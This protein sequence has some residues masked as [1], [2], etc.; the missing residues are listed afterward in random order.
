MVGL[1]L[2]VLSIPSGPT[3]PA[4]LTSNDLQNILHPLRHTA[5]RV[6]TQIETFANNLESFKAKSPRPHDTQSFLEACD[7]MKKYRETAVHSMKELSKN[8]NA[9]KSKHTSPA[10]NR[11]NGAQSSSSKLDEQIRRWQLEAETWDLF[12]QILCVNDPESRIRAKRAAKTSLQILHRYSTD[13][14]VWEKFLEVDHFA[15]ECVVVL[16]WLE[17]TS[18]DFTEDI[19]AL[20]S[21]LE[22]KAERGQG[23]WA[24]GWLY[25]KEAIKGAKRLR[26]WP[27]PLDP[28]DPGITISL[29][30]S[31]QKESLIT[32]LDPDAVTRQRHGLQKQDRFYEQA[33]WLTCWKMLRQGES[34]SKIRNWSEEHLENWR[35]ISLCGAVGSSDGS[36]DDGNSRMMSYKSQESWR[37][38]CSALANN[39]SS[40]PFERAVYALLCGE[41]EPAYA[42]CRGWS[43]HLYVYLNHVILSRYR[44]F[45]KQLSRK[46]SY[47]PSND[48][49]LVLE[50]PAYANLNG[51]LNSMHNNERIK[52]EARNPYRTIQSAIVCQNYDSFFY[53]QANAVSKI[54]SRSNIQSLVP[55][56]ST[57]PQVDNASLIA[58]TDK[59]SVRIVAH[60]FLTLVCIG[61][62]RADSHYINITSNNVVAYIDQLKIS[63]RTEFIPLYA[64]LLP[65]SV[66]QMVLGRV[67]IDVVDPIEREQRV[68]AIKR[69]NID[70]TAVLDN[71]WQWALSEANAKEDTTSPIKLRKSIVKQPDGPGRIGPVQ[72]TLIGRNIPLHDERLIRSVEW[73]RYE[74][75][76][77]PNICSQGAFLYKRF[78]GE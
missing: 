35:A 68:K 32:Q 71:Q 9:K 31:E 13:R 75:N 41:T 40:N 64:S 57:I 2:E 50:P 65:Q 36:T 43:D 47:S 73:R 3:S 66:A 23:L 51:F 52:E 48:M 34:W 37:A 49:A 70:L 27:Q 59:E 17:R 72:K 24:H 62:L 67:L 33:T 25:T 20:I 26:S 55:K 16:K 69:H 21:E 58:A 6:T 1:F 53:N 12:Y 78:F 5:Q 14:E 56:S 60:F 61:G 63:G 45:C 4:P 22:I 42:V 76:P 46:M 74:S 7:L 54:S 11:D 44:E 29:L 8:N 18:K 15:L 30:N 38:A 28:N 10:T 39:P 77:W 19:D